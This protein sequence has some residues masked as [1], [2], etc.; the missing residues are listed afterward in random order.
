MRLPATIQQMI[1]QEPY[2][3][4]DYGMSAS[5]VLVFQDKVLKIQECGR[6]SENEHRMMAWLQGKLP[7]PQVLSYEVQEGSSYLLMSK[8]PGKMACDEEY[9]RDP[10][11][12]AKLLSAGLKMLW[13][14][15]T[16]HCPGNWL[17]ESK[18]AQARYNVEN[19]LVDMDNV[20]PDTFGEKGFQNPRALLQWL[21][22]N[23]PQEEPTL[24]HGDY[25]LPNLFGTGDEPC[26]YID[27][28]K[29]G[30][31]DKWCDIALC[32]RSLSHNFSGRYHN[33]AYQGY[34]EMLL[35][36]ELGLKPDWEKIRYYILLDELF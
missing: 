12:Q 34:D 29:A 13:A 10:A 6:E 24:S 5:S 2:K 16:A 4:D 22:E 28:G 14:V 25:C 17:L 20:E 23:R 1:S 3:T 21:C 31:A 19:N 35:F 33:Q 18:L 11:R 7:V 8:V 9:M 36:R 32:Y 15:D 26:G 27:L 30:I